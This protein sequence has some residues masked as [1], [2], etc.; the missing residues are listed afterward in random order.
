MLLEHFPLLSLSLW[1][2]I[3]GGTINAVNCAQTL[4][5]EGRISSDV[6]LI[7]DEMDLQKCEEYFVGDLV[8]CNSE[9]GLYKG[10]VCFMIVGLKDS[11]PYVT[12]SSPET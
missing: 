4:R 1:D 5:N 6:C 2:K 9:C 12:K 3:R 7:F 10:L 11:I 8:G